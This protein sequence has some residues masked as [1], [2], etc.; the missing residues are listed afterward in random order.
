[1]S[2]DYWEKQGLKGHIVLVEGIG[3]GAAGVSVQSMDAHF[4]VGIK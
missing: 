3:T 2:V 4:Q 1:M